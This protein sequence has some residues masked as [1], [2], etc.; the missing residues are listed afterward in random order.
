[1]KIFKNIA[2]TLTALF[3]L[4]CSKELQQETLGEAVTVQYG[5]TVDVP[6][7]ALGDGKTANYVWYALYRADGSLVNQYAPARIDADRK[8]ICPVTMV[9]DKDYKV[10]FLAMY[11][12]GD[13]PAYAVDA[14]S[15]TVSM[16]TQAQANS[17]K[18]DLF[19]GVDAVVDFQG[20]QNTNVML[21]RVVAQVN[22][23]LSEA[24]WTDLGVN[25]SFT[26]QIEISGAPVSMNLWDGA[27]SGATDVTYDKA[28]IPAEGRKIGSAYCFASAGGDQKVDISISLFNASGTPAKT[29]SV[30]AVPV[31]VN[32]QTNLIIN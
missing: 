28:A 9:K 4:S 32:K 29:A 10:V 19:Y 8:A 22:F 16:P 7:K 20:A 12:E 13:T 24:A 30:S 26:S 27:F 6:T 2:L 5:V 17:D 14:Q 21:N 11:Y 15:K 1:M 18:Y 23:E 3:A 25:E 31:A